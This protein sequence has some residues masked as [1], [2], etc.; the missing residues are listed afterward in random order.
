M[1]KLGTQGLIAG[2]LSILI[3]FFVTYQ[4]AGWV[5]MLINALV[6]IAAIVLGIIGMKREGSEKIQS[7]IGL[8][9]GILTIIIAVLLVIFNN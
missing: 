3:F 7:I 6:V 1:G 4:S 9:L 2:I 5:V 8:A